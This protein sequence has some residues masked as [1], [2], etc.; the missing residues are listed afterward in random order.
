MEDE[1]KL[2]EYVLNENG[3]VFAG[4]NY[5]SPAPCHWAFGQ[6]DDVCLPV[7]EH[8]LNFVSFSTAGR[9]NP[10]QVV[11]AISAG[12]SSRHCSEAIKRTYV[13]YFSK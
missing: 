13:C 2:N 12:V 10:V 9:G 11:R 5:N 7:A 3:K 6:F 1:D 4:G 8:I